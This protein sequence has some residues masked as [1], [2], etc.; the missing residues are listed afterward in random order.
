MT[1]FLDK[2][3]A[4]NGRPVFADGIEYSPFI[5]RLR[6]LEIPHALTQWQFPRIV[7]RLPPESGSFVSNEVFKG[8]RVFH[9]LDYLIAQYFAVLE[10]HG[11]C[12]K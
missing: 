9:P 1:E 12:E 11:R 6:V 7:S 4:E 10:V 2:E 8:S 5:R 3:V